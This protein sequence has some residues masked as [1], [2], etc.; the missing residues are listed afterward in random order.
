MEVFL[1]WIGFFVCVLIAETFWR[2]NVTARAS[3]GVKFQTLSL[4]KQHVLYSEKEFLLEKPPEK[5][6]TDFIN[7]SPSGVASKLDYRHC[8]K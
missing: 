8:N 6:D 3:G 7:T 5:L 1:R 4:S 2:S